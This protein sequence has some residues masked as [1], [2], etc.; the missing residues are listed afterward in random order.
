M[1]PFMIEGNKLTAMSVTRWNRLNQIMEMELQCITA[2]GDDFWGG[3]C[4]RWGRM[5]FNVL[6]GV[7]R[8]K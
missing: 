6:G 2:L 7:N 1:L 4:D 3:D 5:F 8:Q